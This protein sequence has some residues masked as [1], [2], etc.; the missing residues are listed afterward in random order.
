MKSRL[1]AIVVLLFAPGAAMAGAPCAPPDITGLYTGT[2]ATP[3]GANVDLTLN[4]YCDAGHISAQIFTSMGDFAVKA[5]TAEDRQVS[6][7]FDTGASLGT[8]AATR[9]DDTLAGNFVL[10][11]DSGTIALRRTG[12]ALGA[13]AMKPNLDLTAAQWHADLRFLADELPRRHANAF[14]FISKVAFEAEVAS[15]DKRIDTANADEIFVGLQQIVKSIGDGHTG[16][17]TPP[18]DRRVIPIEIARFGDDFRIAAVGPGLDAALGA[19]LLKVGDMP[20][21]DAWQHVLTLTSQAELMGLRQEDAL[22]YLSRGYAL[23]GLDIV[24]DRNRVVYTLRDDSGH[25]FQQDVQGLAPDRTVDM[26]SGYSDAALR[27]QKKDAPFWCKALPEDKAVYCGWR[28]YQ[29]LASNAKTM[30]ALIDRTHSQK[31][32]ID[33]RDNG[34]GDNTVGYA[35][36]V[37]P[38]EARS[39]LNRKGRLFVLIGP[40]TFSAAMNN[41][42]QFAD[43]TNAILAGETIGE[44][45]NSYQEPRQFRLPNSHLVIRASTLYYEFRKHGENA[46][47]PNKEIIPTWDDVKAGRDPVM[48]WVLAQKVG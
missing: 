43:E 10:A 45:P 8:L 46:V 7:D 2:A 9:K 19:R 34:G 20:V 13:D 16:V 37:K 11:G 30:F 5:V 28:S 22:V 35:E 36:L 32:V 17:G 3:G 1:A 33:M 14:F 18:P 15:L 26:K 41:A 12:D 21:A 48:D 27:F 4:L 24:P 6:L 47:R 40:L 31:L 29:N 38:L 44:R 23:H 39:D 42:A 25:V